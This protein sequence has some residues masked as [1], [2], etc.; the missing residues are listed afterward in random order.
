MIERSVVKGII[1]P[2]ITPVDEQENLDV[3]RLRKI[4][5][6]VIDNGVHGILAFGSNSEFYMFDD[7]DMFT[8][9]DVILEE[10]AGRVPVYFGIGAIRT[11]KCIQ[12][13]KEAAKRD[14][15]AISVL[16]PMFIK[17]TDK[18][19]YNHFKAIANSVPHTAMLLYN[20][21]G[22]CGY[23]MPLKVV[24]DLAHDVPNI[25]GIKDSSGDIT[26]CSELVRLTRDVDFR[27]LTGK[28]TTIYPGLCMGAVGSVCS[29]ANMY[30]QLVSSIYDFYVEGELDKALEAQFRLNP[31]RLSQ[32]PASFPAATKDMAN[33]MGLDVGK[34]IL[35]TEATEGNI[36]KA[37]K[38]A[39]HTGG[40]LETLD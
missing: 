1:V 20:N 34:S 17:P 5:N 22:R 8:A 39:M 14:I 35:P 6:H 28:D 31:I 16:Q 7:E 38:E 40:F 27:V 23:G 19:L 33:L 9:L 18:A 2:L 29:T 30:T 11:R 21:P 4:V 24:L 25:I 32:D 12:L 37:M 36:L 10:A 15:A 3:E 26:N 13:A